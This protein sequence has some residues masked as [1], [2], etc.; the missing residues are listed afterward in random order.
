MFVWLIRL[1]QSSS[2]LRF[3]S[4]YLNLR[5]K[6][7]YCS[8]KYKRWIRLSKHLRTIT[9]NLKA[10][11]TIPAKSLI[12]TLYHIK[13]L[14]QYNGYSNT[15]GDTATA[16]LSQRISTHTQLPNTEYMEISSVFFPNSMLTKIGIALIK[17]AARKGSRLTLSLRWS[18]QPAQHQSVSPYPRI[19]SVMYCM[20]TSPDQTGQAAG[21]NAG[22][23]WREYTSRNT[24][25]P[26]RP[27]V[28]ELDGYTNCSHAK[29]R[30]EN[31]R[32]E[33]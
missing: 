22:G 7:D 17:T 20:R 3:S 16:P 27:T 5:I 10:P 25:A 14:I 31:E 11:C 12:N 21:W 23:R 15:M 26:E 4:Y 6:K 8:G 18:K 13:P 32:L 19:I 33:I 2:L 24:L 28:E 29:K 30:R 9:A 1:Y